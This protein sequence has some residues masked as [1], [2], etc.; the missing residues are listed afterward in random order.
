MVVFDNLSEHPYSRDGMVEKYQGCKVRTGWSKRAYRAT[1][2][3]QWRLNDLL[4]DSECTVGARHLSGVTRTHYK[5]TRVVV[6]K[7]RLDYLR[8]C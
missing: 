3:R 6:F 8:S 1:K 7:Y 2:D 5:G 4:E